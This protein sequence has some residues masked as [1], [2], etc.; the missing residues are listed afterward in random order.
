MEFLNDQHKQNFEELTERF[1]F[2]IATNSDAAIAFI[3]ATPM[4]YKVVDTSNRFDGWLID[5]EITY[6]G[7]CTDFYALMGVALGYKLGT[8]T[9]NYERMLS[10]NMWGAIVIPAAEILVNGLEIMLSDSLTLEVA[11]DG[12]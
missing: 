3:T 5:N 9:G 4:I 6:A 10:A 8:S 12:Q 2:E 11:S 1:K 7:Q